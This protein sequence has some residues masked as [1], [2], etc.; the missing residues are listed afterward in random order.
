[1]G[2]NIRIHSLS[3]G[4]TGLNFIEYFCVY[5]KRNDVTYK[6]IVIICIV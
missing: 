5:V 6:Y 2:P 1:M 3:G 4:E